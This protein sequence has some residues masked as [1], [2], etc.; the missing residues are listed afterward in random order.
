MKRKIIGISLI[1]AM[2]SLVVCGTLAYFTDQG[3]AHNV[4]TSGGISIEL[5]EWA[6]AE[7][8]VEFPEDGISNVMPGTEVIKI[9][10]VKNTA[11]DTAYI[12]VSVDTEISVE[13]ADLSFIGIDFN[14][15]DWTY[16]DGF[17][18]YNSPLAS[19]EISVPLFTKVSFSKDMGNAYQYSTVNIDAAAYAVQI[20]N[21]GTNALDA[22]GWPEVATPII[23]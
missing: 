12:R 16:K 6:D 20:A 9:L 13:N 14:N 18:Y 4:I 15:T 5:L 23:K 7:K 2:L 10:E 19:G 8:K 17:Y 3:T 11:N 21:N 1:V 22:E